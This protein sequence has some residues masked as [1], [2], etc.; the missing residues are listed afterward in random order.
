MSFASPTIGHYTNVIRGPVPKQRSREP[1][2]TAS[3]AF[4][5]A[6]WPLSSCR[7]PRL[8]Q[9]RIGRSRGSANVRTGDLGSPLAYG[10][11]ARL[12][13]V[14]AGQ[15]HRLRANRM[16]PLVPVPQLH[17]VGRDPDDAEAAP[18]PGHLNPGTHS[19]P[20]RR[21]APLDRK[22]RSYPPSR[23]VRRGAARRVGVGAD[24]CA[25]RLRPYS[26]VDC[27]RLRVTV[28]GFYYARRATSRTAAARRPAPRSNPRGC[29]RDPCRTSQT[30]SAR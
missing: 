11:W 21:L 15:L 2:S 10:S 24:R 17:P 6:D 25:R 19:N 9:Q 4:L 5:G 20:A 12:S 3:Q 26:R 14:M 22:G 29:G 8:R 30:S 23:R 13:R 18:T 28:L 1:T 16:P 27:R 7:F